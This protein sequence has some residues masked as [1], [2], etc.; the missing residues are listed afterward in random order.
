MYP[1]ATGQLAVLAQGD[2]R[3]SYGS[4]ARAVFG[5][6]DAPAALLPSP[7]SPIPGASIAASFIYDGADSPFRLHTEGGLHASDFE[8]VRLYSAEGSIIDGVNGGIGALRI[9][10]PKAALISAGLEV[11]DL[12]FRGQHLYASDITRI[13]AGRDFYNS[14]LG[15][16]RSVSFVELG[17]PGTLVV[18]AGR[19]VGPITSANDALDFGYLPRGNPSYPGIRTIGDQNNAYLPRDGASVLIA[20]GVAPGVELGDFA[21]TY[22]DP[23]VLHDPENPDD[24][25]GTPDYSDRLVAFT[26]QVEADRLRRA[27]LPATVDF[28]PVQAWEY[29]QD[30]PAYRQQLLVY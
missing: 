23:A 6:I 30:M 9:D 5:M 4:S 3:F 26:E 25:L 18:E 8:P 29:F 17:G 2:L 27:G 13:A 16:G 1:S 10:L 20:F 21:A 15:P 12:I 7:L 28:S 19:N 11:V 22:I 24:A 14:T